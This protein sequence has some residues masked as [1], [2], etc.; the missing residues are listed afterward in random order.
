MPPCSSLVL[1]GSQPC[2]V[3]LRR[4]CSCPQPVTQTPVFPPARPSPISPPAASHPLTQSGLVSE[5]GL[6]DGCQWALGPNGNPC[7]L[8]QTNPEARG[9][10]NRAERA[11]PVLL[12]TPLPPCQHT[13]EQVGPRAPPPRSPLVACRRA[14]PLLIWP[15]PSRRCRLSPS[16]LPRCSP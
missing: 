1:S 7:L 3:Y 2:A 6:A 10:L 8:Q 5:G 9:I 12:G 4:G 15:F 13:P 11:S 14:S 16:L